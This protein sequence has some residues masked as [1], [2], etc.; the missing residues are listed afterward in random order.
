MEIFG[1]H[2]MF[3]V[4]ADLL[5]EMLIR[6]PPV[7]LMI[8]LG[9]YKPAQLV[10][11]MDTYDAVSIAGLVESMSYNDRDLNWL[12]ENLKPESFTWVDIKA[13]LLTDK[14]FPTSLPAG[15]IQV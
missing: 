15:K 1:P 4:H 8:P 14:R 7:N 11:A 5:R 13:L 10:E 6:F 3:T 2:K 9:F 12:M